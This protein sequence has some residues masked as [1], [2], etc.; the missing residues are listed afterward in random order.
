MLKVN[1]VKARSKL[2]YTNKFPRWA[3]A[4]K[5]EAQELTTLLSDVLWSVGRTGKITPL[6]IVEPVELAGATIG[7]AT[8]NN[9]DDIMRKKVKIGSYV[10]IRRSNEVIPEI[11]GLAYDTA[12]SK[13]IVPPV[14]CPSC[15]FTLE[16]DG[17]NL[18]CK[19]YFGCPEQIKGR[20][21]HYCSKGAMNLEG[22]S[23]KTIEQLYEKLGVKN[24]ADLYRLNKE[25]FTKLEGFKDKKTDNF[26]SELQ[27][28]KD[29]KLENFIYALAIE[30]VGEKTAKDL[31]REFGTLDN[32][33]NADFDHLNSIPNIGEITARG[34]LDYLNTHHNVIID[35]L[36]VGVTPKPFIKKDTTG[37]YF[38]KKTIV[39]TGGLNSY[40]RDDLTLLLES[41]GAKVASSVSKNTD[42]VIAGEGAKSKLTKAV[43]LGIK[44]IDEAELIKLISQNS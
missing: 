27:R 40:T 31:A 29:C 24:F 1:D 43:E 26:Y 36:F 39:L 18:Y 19:N 30:N 22:V 4:Y 9:Y 7:R 33:L 44:V 37:S 2:G 12:D 14:F 23:D 5:F 13:D 28:S 8:L 20:L 34:V 35:L 10:F 16:N 15:G 41:L 11:L 42:L 21:S 38:D 25:D 32:L 3:M 6:A 17:V